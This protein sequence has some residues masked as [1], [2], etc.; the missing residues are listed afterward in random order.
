MAQG[1]SERQ[2]LV[3]GRGGLPA[4][5]L[6]AEEG[7]L[8]GGVCQGGGHVWAAQRNG[9]QPKYLQRTAQHLQGKQC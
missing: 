9:L 2:R 4:H 3:R 8:C 5:L 7:L 6:I 1:M